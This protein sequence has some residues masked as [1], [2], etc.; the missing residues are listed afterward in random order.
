MLSAKPSVEM[1]AWWNVFPTARAPDSLVIAR[2]LWGLPG[3]AVEALAAEGVAAVL[4][5]LLHGRGTVHPLC[6][7]LLG[8]P[9]LP[10]SSS[11]F[12][13]RSLRE[14]AFGEA[15]SDRFEAVA[16]VLNSLPGLPE[17]LS[18]SATAALCLPG[19]C[20]KCSLNFYKVA[21]FLLEGVTFGDTA[22]AL[23]QL[24]VA[25]APEL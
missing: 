19:C 7:F 2:L 8:G 4:L 16:R 3:P 9:P 11:L 1:A 24:W 15:C 25:G 22:A 5:R 23:E 17:G 18:S 10:E 6:E 21:C 14:A 13:P 20:R 12:G